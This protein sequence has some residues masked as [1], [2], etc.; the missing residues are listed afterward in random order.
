MSNTK[1]QLRGGSEGRCYGTRQTPD[2]KERVEMIPLEWAEEVVRAR[3]SALLS[4]VREEVIGGNLSD[5][6]VDDYVG[7]MLKNSKIAPDAIPEVR[8]MI[9]LSRVFGINQQKEDSRTKLDQL[10]K[11]LKNDSSRET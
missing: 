10:S 6:E 11:E 7:D 4:R 2:G 5:A 1:E 9:I 3:E 8:T